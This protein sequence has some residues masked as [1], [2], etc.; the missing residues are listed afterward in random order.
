MNMIEDRYRVLPHRDV[1]A[2]FRW[3]GD[4]PV[5]YEHKPCGMTLS[6]RDVKDANWCPHCAKTINKAAQRRG[7]A[8]WRI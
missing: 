3:P 4:L 2:V 1:L 7:F 5:A 6:E 8:E